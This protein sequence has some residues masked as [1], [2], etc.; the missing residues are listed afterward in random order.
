MRAFRNNLI[1]FL[2]IGSFCW[3]ISCTDY[4]SIDVKKIYQIYPNKNIIGI[5]INCD[6]L[7]DCLN[8]YLTL[9]DRQSKSSIRVKIQ[10]DLPTWIDKIENDTIFVNIRADSSVYLY[11]KTPNLQKAV[12]KER[13]L[14]IKYN[15]VRTKG[16]ALVTELKTTFV[17]IQKDSLF[18]LIKDK[19]MQIPVKNI[20]NYYS[21]YYSSYDH[22]DSFRQNIDFD[23]INKEKYFTALKNEYFQ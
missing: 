16:S 20:R 1:P 7:D 8:Q 14:I 21:L 2:F 6:E 5:I 3:C 11:I 13:K 22:T 15:K 10:S 17:K 12:L 4:S 23:N 9:I 18:V 19:P